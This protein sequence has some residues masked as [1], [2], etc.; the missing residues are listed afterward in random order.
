VS[1]PCRRCGAEIGAGLLACPSCHA[2]VHAERLEALA[3]RARE[4]EAGD[5]LHEALET[6]RD[7]LLLLPPGSNQHAQ[8]SGRVRTLSDRAA[9]GPKPPKAKT[10]PGRL[11]A[12]G[13]IGLLIWKFKSVLGFMA[14]KGKLL[15]GGLTKASTF[16]SMLLSFGLYWTVFG[17]KFAG[18]LILSIY[19]H[20]MGH[21]ASLRRHGIRAGAPAFIPGF[22]AVVRLKQHPATAREDAS[23]GLAGPEWGLG[24]AVACALIGLATGSGVWFAAA[25]IGAWINLFNLLP[26]WQL[27]GSRG[28]A[29]LTRPMRF[30]VVVGFA[31]GWY[32]VQDGLLLLLAIA[33][34]IRTLSTA[35]ASEEDAHR[36]ILWRFLFLIAALSALCLIEVPGLP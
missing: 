29:A 14:T 36:P 30:A 28:F 11:A 20:E 31:G 5:R 22:G 26:V 32:V 16:F 13:A 2:L 3:A 1:G 21:V 23:V 18:L 6:W 12:L 27:D 15:L 19:V 25:R 33:A 10:A 34:L 35:A 4:A 17:W 9:D 24:A 7:A 8:L